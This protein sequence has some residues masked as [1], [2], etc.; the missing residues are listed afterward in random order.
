MLDDNNL[1]YSLSKYW[2]FKS[3][4]SCSCSLQ[5]TYHFCCILYKILKHRFDFDE[6][7][8]WGGDDALYDIFRE[9]KN[10]AAYC[11]ILQHT[12][13]YCSILVQPPKNAAYHVS[14]L[15]VPV[16]NWYFLDSNNL[17]CPLSEYPILD[18][19]C[20]YSCVLLHTY[21]SWDIL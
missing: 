15:K 1:A 3:W 2:T 16:N 17:G 6:V 13:A 10:C 19:Q 12:A 8:S 11:S 14:P 18:I 9:L 4:W 21:C 5:H 20:S 7:W